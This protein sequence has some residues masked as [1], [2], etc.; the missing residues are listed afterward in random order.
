MVLPLSIHPN[1]V[2]EGPGAFGGLWR[3]QGWAPSC[4]DGMYGKNYATDEIKA[5]ILACV[6]RGNDN[7]SG[8]VRAAQVRELLEEQY[9]G[10]YC[11]PGNTEITKVISSSVQKEKN[12]TNSKTKKE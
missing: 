9:P 3:Q 12:K 11:L 8:R 1:K 4:E 10:N 2:N 5:F 6:Q 7:T